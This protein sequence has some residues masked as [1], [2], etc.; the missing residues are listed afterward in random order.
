[1][2]GKQLTASLNKYLQTIYSIYLE[3]HIIH[4]VDV[5]NALQ[6]SKPSV[7]R[8]VHQLELQGLVSHPPYQPLTL[9]ES[10]LKLGRTLSDSISLMR[11]LLIEVMGIDSTLADCDAPRI[12]HALSSSA[13]DMMKGKMQWLE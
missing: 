4:M 8:A 1:M 12:A 7:C 13:A 9:T 3:N 5:A 11:Y 6:V 10:G 2:R